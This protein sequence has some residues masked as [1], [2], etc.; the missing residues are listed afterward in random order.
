[1]LVRMFS[2]LLKLRISKVILVTGLCI[3]LV[4]CG[5]GGGDQ[6]LVSPPDDDPENG[7]NDGPNFRFVLDPTIVARASD[8]F[9]ENANTFYPAALEQLNALPGLLPETVIITYSDCGAA[10]AFY[11]PSDRTITL[12]SELDNAQFGLLLELGFDR[13][14]AFSL[15]DF[16]TAFVMD[17]EIGHALVDILD[18]AVAG[19]SE[20]TADAIATVLSVERSLGGTT[21]PYSLFGGLSLADQPTSYGDEHGNGQDRSG[22]IIC[23]TVGG[24]TEL[25][26]DAGVSNL[27]QPFVEA[28][29]DCTA[30]YQD[31]LSAVRRWLPG[32][33][34]R[35]AKAGAPPSFTNDFDNLIQNRMGA[36]SGT[37]DAAE[38]TA[39][40]ELHF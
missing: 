33:S 18:I 28:G 40:K 29:R 10:N 11:R 19:N 2:F 8:F 30:E 6:A 31:Q 38:L 5:G 24:R 26:F 20:S 23:W 36:P 9:V 21:R 16:S 25:L 14:T 27:V 39:T 4:A 7:N 22:D 3:S 35:L 12:C 15:S 37:V 34:P 32:F 1:M 13:D 17:H